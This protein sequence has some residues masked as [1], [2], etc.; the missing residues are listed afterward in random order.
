[1]ERKHIAI[2][3]VSLAFALLVFS[4]PSVISAQNYSGEVVIGNSPPEFVG[5]PRGYSDSVN[6]DQPVTRIGF[7]AEGSDAN[8][9]SYYMIVCPTYDIEKNSDGI[10]KCSKFTYCR[11]NTVASGEMA[12]C[13]YRTEN[14]N[15]LEEDSYILLCDN[16]SGTPLC[17]EPL[18]SNEPSEN[19]HFDDQADV[20]GIS[21]DDATSSLPP[22]NFTLT[23]QSIVTGGFILI[24]AISV[25]FLFQALKN[26]SAD[27]RALGFLSLSIVIIITFFG[28]TSL[29]SKTQDLVKNQTS[30]DIQGVSEER[31]QLVMSESSVKRTSKAGLYEIFIKPEIESKVIYYAQENE[32]FPILEEQTDWVR[33]LLPNGNEGWIPKSNTR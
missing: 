22:M 24:T 27:R 21:A 29:T 3:I 8:G 18:N 2:T 13:S 9:D 10:Y 23:S 25:I 26:E 7:E 17:T 12:S 31:E 19:H 1:M 32:P 33:I 5:I 16:N 14:P 15:A 20:L 30:S 11:S 4:F 28:V 6:P